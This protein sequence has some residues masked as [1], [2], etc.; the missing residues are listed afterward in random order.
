MINNN[1]VESYTVKHV[2]SFGQLEDGVFYFVGSNGYTVHRCPC[3]C[4]IPLRL[5]ITETGW[6]ITDTNNKLNINHSINKDTGCKSH[7]RIIDNKV[8]W[9]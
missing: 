8:D 3:G 6:Q 7:Y 2:E 1:V 9:C 4:G 5:M